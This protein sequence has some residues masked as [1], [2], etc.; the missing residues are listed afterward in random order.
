ML[1]EAPSA[2]AVT[3]SRSK[4]VGGHGGGRKDS[5]LAGKAASCGHSSEKRRAGGLGEVGASQ[6]TGVTDTAL[7]PVCCPSSAPQLH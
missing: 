3:W 4:D 2:T 1:G 6:D 5:S 7:V